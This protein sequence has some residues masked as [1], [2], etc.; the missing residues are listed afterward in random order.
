MK[1]RY[2]IIY[3]ETGCQGT[4]SEATARGFTES[5]DHYVIDSEAGESIYCGKTEP[6]PEFV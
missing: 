3:P 1:F 5:E 6:L 2:Y 4:N